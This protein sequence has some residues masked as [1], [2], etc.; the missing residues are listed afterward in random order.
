MFNNPSDTLGKGINVIVNL[1][2]G[3]KTAI[4]QT[5]KTVGEMITSALIYKDGITETRYGLA[6][7]R[8]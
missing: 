4:G 5:I 7:E 1:L 8:S 3:E 6:M 2:G